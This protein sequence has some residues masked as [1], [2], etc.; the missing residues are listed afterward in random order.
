MVSS[1]VRPLVTSEILGPDPSGPKFMMQQCG[2]NPCNEP[3]RLKTRHL[4]C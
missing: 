3:R 1:E 4:G 2:L